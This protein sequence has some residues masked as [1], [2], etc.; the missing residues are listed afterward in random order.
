MGATRR[1]ALKLA[2][3]SLAGLAL[4]ACGP[5]FG[6]VP[7]AITSGSPGAVYNQLALALAGTWTDQLKIERPAVQLSAGSGQNV[8]RLLE[9]RADVGFVAAD[10]AVARA[11][12]PLRALSRMHFDYVHVVTSSNS[13]LATVADLRGCRVSVGSEESGVDLV[14]RRVLEGAGLDADRDVDA[15]R[16]SIDQSIDA[17]ARGSLDALF[18][19]GGLPTGQISAL[20]RGGAARL[21]PLGD[22]ASGVVDRY[23]E[24]EP[25]EIPAY[26][27]TNPDAVP[28]LLVPNFLMATT[29]MPN[30]VAAALTRAVFDGRSALIAASPAAWAIDSRSGADTAPVPLHEGA[31]SYFRSIG[32][33]L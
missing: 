8:T 26:T 18:W 7:L 25:G 2:G 19:S 31:K 32:R 23:P 6:P 17:L 20:L 11:A 9:E 1:T 13:G 5:D 21:V 14:A 28:T 24:Y 16:L 4:T 3:G 30:D 12:S 29:R 10:E 22:V 33:E 15:Q 27:Y